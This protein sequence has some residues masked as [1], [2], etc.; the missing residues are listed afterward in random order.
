M[1]KEKFPVLETERLICREI[2]A[3]D[4]AVL[5]QYWSDPIVMEYLSLAP[6]KRMEETLEMISLVTHM[7]ETGEG[8][9]W[10]ITRRQDGKLLGTCGFH[11]GKPEHYRFEMGYELGK[12]YWRQGIM[13]EALRKIL[14]YGFSNMKLNRVEAFVNHGNIRSTGILGKLGFQLD[15]I[16]RE[17]ERN[18][19]QFVNQ[20]C[21]SLLKAEW[22]PSKTL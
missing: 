7:P 10:A 5:H 1:S 15:G 22:E 21:F 2:T 19:G 4:A 3:E 18:Q 12:E 14:T 11:N 20:Y 16:L 9:R 8:F 17:Y 13:T 6:F